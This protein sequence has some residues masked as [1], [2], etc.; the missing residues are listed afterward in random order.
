MIEGVSVA[1]AAYNGEKYIAKQIDSITRQLKKNDEIIISYNQSTDNTER[2]IKEYEH[3]DSRIKVIECKERGILKNFENAISKCSKEIIFLSDQD[4]IWVDNKV[5]IVLDNFSSKNI[6]A[7]VHSGILVDDKEEEIGEIG[8]IKKRQYASPIGI[9]YRNQIQ[10]SCMAF[11]KSMVNAILPFPKKI[12]MHDS[13]IG[14]I[15]SSLG[16]VLLIPD[17]LLLYRQHE[18]NVTSRHHGNV[19]EMI[20]QRLHL[21]IEYIKRTRLIRKGL[22]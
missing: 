18:N 17:L 19:I 7:V 22:L 13:W 10:G 2:I 4:D 15:L 11:R 16:K 14:M 6:L 20:S 5:N 9:L 1:L 21:L 3:K 8:L 12:P